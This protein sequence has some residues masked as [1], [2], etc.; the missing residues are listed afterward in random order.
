MTDTAMA[1]ETLTNSEIIELYKEVGLCERHFN[2]LES[3]YR[4]Q[5]GAWALSSVAAVGFVALT[6]SNLGSGVDRDVICAIIAFLG[7]VGIT[8][9]WNLDVRVYHQ[10]LDC[11]FIEGLNLEIKYRWL[12]RARRIVL[13]K[14]ANGGS[15]YTKIKILQHL[16]YFYCGIVLFL[17]FI[18]I[19]FLLKW[20]IS[21]INSLKGPWGAVILILFFASIAWPWLIYKGTKS[22]PISEWVEK[23]KKLND[24]D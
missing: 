2:E 18:S 12:P 20:R 14:Y 1:D 4:F 19:L 10:L 16:R 7:A 15:E 21:D 13:A 22:I 17:I 5:A 8:L 11:H 9:I 23:Q 3:K 6:P 24:D